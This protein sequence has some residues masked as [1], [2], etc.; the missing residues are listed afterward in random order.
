MV[1]VLHGHLT[2]SAPA[3]LVLITTFLVSAWLGVRPMGVAF[4]IGITPG[5]LWWAVA[6]PRWRDWVV[7]RGI[8]P[9]KVQTLAAITGLVWPRGSFFEKTEFPRRN[10]KQGW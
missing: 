6:V 5:W 2:V 10:G 8:D 7:D 4:G 3:A 1:A 9:A